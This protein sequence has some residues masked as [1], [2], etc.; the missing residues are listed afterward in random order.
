MDEI[1]K[2][3]GELGLPEYAQLFVKHD[4]DFS[5]VRE[6]DDGD[7]K[8]LGISLGHRRRLLRAIADLDK[9]PSAPVPVSVPLQ[10]DLAER[11]QLTVMFCDLAGSTALS[12][13]LDPEDMREVIRSYQDVCTAVIRSY[14]AFLAKYMGDGI[15]VYFGYPRAR[16]DSAE[17]AVRAAL[18]IVA[19][20]E[21][22]TTRV[23][24]SLKVRVG[25][26]TGPVVV[27]DLV[28]DGAAQ[29]RA[30][31]G[32]APNLAARLQ[33]LVDPGKVVI[34]ESTRRLLG[35]L[36]DL[37]NRDRNDAQQG[38]AAAMALTQAPMPSSPGGVA[39]AANGATFRGEYAFGASLTYRLPIDA[40]M[41]LT[42][43]AA[44]AGSKNNGA[45]VGIAGEF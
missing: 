33:G 1:G 42:V 37:R 28:G 25:I 32:E 16:E 45:R 36:F 44:F 6:L 31:V 4:I 8:D 10:H 38:I 23:G 11:R 19:A 24:I 7:L 22:L 27:G 26:A 21:G 13:Q 9:P 18:D 15:L 29:E 41:A 40:V 2:W 30:V 20:V 35:T 39:Y 3:L 14:D 12:T 5:V 17:C 34:A 43:G